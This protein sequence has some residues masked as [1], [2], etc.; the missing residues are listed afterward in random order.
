MSQHLHV[1]LTDADRQHLDS[2][3]RHGTAPARVQNRARILL[4]SDRSA[5]EKRSRQEVAT[6]T[7]CN[8][9]TV[10]NVCR[11][12]AKEGMEAALTEKPRPGQTPKIT[13]DIEAQMIALVCSNPPVGHA[14]WTLRLIASQMVELG[15]I[16]SITNVAVHQRLKKTNLSLGK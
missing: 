3:I 11:R 12:F 4:L 8:A 5:G 9:V 6:A 1:S 7:L 2:L 14:R 16:D 15:Y 13:G 10:G